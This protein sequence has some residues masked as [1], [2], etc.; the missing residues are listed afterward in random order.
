MSPLFPAAEFEQNWKPEIDK[1]LVILQHTG[2]RHDTAI[3]VRL[4]IEILALTSLNW[5]RL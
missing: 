3:S 5:V 1:I 4:V 2:R